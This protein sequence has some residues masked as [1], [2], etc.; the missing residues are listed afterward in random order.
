MSLCLVLFS[1]RFGFSKRS[2]L[3]SSGRFLDCLGMLGLQKRRLSALLIKKAETNSSSPPMPSSK[4]LEL[5]IA[6]GI[7]PFKNTYAPKL[8][9]LEPHNIDL[10]DASS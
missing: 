4:T 2:V 7:N 8:R 6:P 9:V 1:Q 3:G 5:W 10:S